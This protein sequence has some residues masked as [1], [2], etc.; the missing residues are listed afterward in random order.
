MTAIIRPATENDAE[1]I[2]AIYA[3]VVRQTAISFELE[4]PTVAEMRR[5][6][7]ETLPQ[8]PWLV[9]AGGGR[10]LG[11]AYAG[12]HR[13]RAAY[14]WSVDTS[15]YIHAEM[16]R[17]GI[18]RA[19]YRSLLPILA[20]QNYYNAYA[21]IA[22]P[23]PGSV[24]LHEAIGFRALGVYR[25]VGYKL[26]AWHDVGWWCLSLQPKSPTPPPPL[27]AKEAQAKP[28]WRTALAA[29]AA[30]LHV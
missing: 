12:K 21:G 8:F 25:E 19:L 26:G 10:V 4:P 27:S 30:L 11:Y 6:I 29:G 16:H 5:R 9:C 2:Q 13:A 28:E 22:L 7:A 15:V 20:V 23:N 24:G 1:Q 14:Q 18:G 17:H 3:P